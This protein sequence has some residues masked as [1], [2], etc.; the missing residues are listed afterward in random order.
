MKKE[1][2]KL[3]MVDISTLRWVLNQLITRG[4]HSVWLD[5]LSLGRPGG[6]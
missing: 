4:Y 3:F 2:Y 5:L 1:N 6:S